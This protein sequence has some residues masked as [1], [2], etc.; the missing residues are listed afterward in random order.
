MSVFLSAFLLVLFCSIQSLKAHGFVA[1]VTER[2]PEDSQ[3]EKFHPCPR[4]VHLK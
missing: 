4:N 3:D 2:T 1:C